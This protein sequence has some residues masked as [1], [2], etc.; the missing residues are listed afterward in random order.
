MSVLNRTTLG[1][2]IIGALNWG[3]VGLAN[4]DPVAAIMGDGSLL[5]RLVYLLVGLS[6]VYQASAAWMVATLRA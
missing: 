6:G 4:F 3:F 5:S 1:F 2:V